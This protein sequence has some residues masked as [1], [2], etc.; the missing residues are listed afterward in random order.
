MKRSTNEQK[1]LVKKEKLK[2][3]W[4]EILSSSMRVCKYYHKSLVAISINVWV[5]G[6]EFNPQATILVSFPIKQNC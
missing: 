4:Y 3:S 6:L 2:N 1:K 5:W